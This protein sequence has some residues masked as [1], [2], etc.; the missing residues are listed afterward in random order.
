MT[1]TGDTLLPTAYFPPVSYFAFLANSAIT[2]IEQMETFPKQTY[3]N[4]CEIMNASGKARLIVP[5]TKPQGNHTI[6]R[7]IEICYRESWQE[8]H[9]K[10]LQSAYSSSPFFSYYADIIQPMFESRETFL[11]KH[12]HEILQ[13]IC[14]LIGIGPSVDFTKDYIKEQHGLLDLRTKFSTKST[15]NI[16]EFP[17]YQQVFEYKFGFIPGLSI[18][19]LLFNLGPEAGSYLDRIVV[20]EVDS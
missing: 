8:Q 10:T 5:V 15:L 6:T 20:K 1:V 12:N 7:N 19:D 18:L 11:V 13:T 4:R 9:W 14:G 17:R 2:Y 16:I 3:R